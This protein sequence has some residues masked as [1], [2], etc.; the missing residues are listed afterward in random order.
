MAASLE[1]TVAPAYPPRPA[2]AAHSSSLASLTGDKS[3]T[4]SRAPS[5]SQLPPLRADGRDSPIE[6]E[7]ALRMRRLSMGDEGAGEGEELPPVDGGRGAWLFVLAGFILETFIWGFSFAF[8]SVL[9]YLQQHDPWRSS[10]LAALSAIGTVL[11]A[12]QFILPVSVI[13]VFRRYPD[14]VKTL[15][16]F[17]GIVNCGSMLVASWA[18]E[19]W[20]LILLIGVL[21]GASGAVLYAPVLLWLNEWWHARRG[22]ASGIVFAGTGIGGLAF[23]FLLS[24]LLARGGF[25][26]M[27]RVWAGFTAFVYAI[28]IWAIKP[29]V[30]PRKPKGPRGPWLVVDWDFLRKE[31]FWVMLITSALS[32]LATFPVSLYLPTYALGLTTSTNSDLIVSLFNASSSF[33]STATGYLSD[34]SLPLTLTIMGLAGALLSLLCWG[35]AGSLGSVF[36]FAVLFA[37]FTQICSAWGAA[38]R[39]SAGSNPHSSTIA[40]CAFGIVRGVASIVGPFVSTTL[41]DPPRTGKGED[42]AWGRFGFGSVIIFVGVMSFASAFGGAG[43]WW[44]RKRAAGRRV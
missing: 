35:F 42:L 12:I 33:G 21:G 10:S 27:C 23:P 25:P 26:L 28:A 16:W 38:T 18:T 14:W 43:V 34:Y 5:L 37:F 22:L 11:L 19:T 6:E 40:F 29:R 24:A 3:P 32:S 1:D 8:P 4:L 39:E 9:V 36:A 31:V 2:A 13:M 15:L 20:Q 17:S 30:P 44:A 41:Y 7:P